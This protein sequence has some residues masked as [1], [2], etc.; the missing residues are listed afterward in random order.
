MSYLSLSLLGLQI[1]LTIGS[2]PLAASIAH[3]YY[4]AILFMISPLLI[5][6]LK[7]ILLLCIV[8]IKLTDL[9]SY[10]IP[11]LILFLPALSFLLIR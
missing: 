10:L 1:D 8:L 11:I 2:L 5:R 6:S 9:G 7:L 3:H 4:L